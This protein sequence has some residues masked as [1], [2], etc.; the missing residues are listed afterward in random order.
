MRITSRCEYALR[1]M[2]YLASNGDEKP[3][4]LTEI[5]AREKIPG[6][7]LER[8]LARLRKAE[9][10]RATRGVNGGYQLARSPATISVSDIVVA[11][12]GPLTVSG[13][14]SVEEPC[15]R[16]ATCVS[17]IAWQR[18]DDAVKNA[19]DGVTLADLLG[20]RAQVR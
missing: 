7:F 15:A 2:V 19:L 11:L 9:L 8:I 5:V 16:A 6:P 10:V 18:L 4:P 20:E 14:S 17:R 1:A 13:C 3:V 12:E